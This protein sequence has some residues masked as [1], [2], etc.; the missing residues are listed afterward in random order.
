M[1]KAGIQ[2]RQL[3]DNTKCLATLVMSK[4]KRRTSTL[5]YTTPPI[6]R[7]IY[8]AALGVM[9]NQQ[10]GCDKQ[11]QNTR[12][13]KDAEN[14]PASKTFYRNSLMLGAPRYSTSFLQVKHNNDC[15]I[16]KNICSK[17]NHKSHLRHASLST[18][19]TENATKMIFRFSFT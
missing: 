17:K 9:Q 13:L 10:E 4:P 16:D 18:V 5:Q 2:R 3:F 6:I 14:R 15:I 7:L 19:T 11:Q 12:I 1:A 8:P